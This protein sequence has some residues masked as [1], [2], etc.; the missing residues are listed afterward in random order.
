MPLQIRCWRALLLLT[1]ACSTTVVSA[2]QI[3]LLGIASIPGTASDL[4]GM[5]GTFSG[6]TPHNQM[7][8]FSALEYDARRNRYLV[9]PDRGPADGAFEYHC[10]FHE[11][12]ITLSPDKRQSVSAKL[13]ASHMLIDEKGHPFVGLAAAIND[14]HPELSRRFDP[15]GIRVGSDGT[16]YVC[17]EYGPHLFAFDTAGKLRKRVPVPD[18][19]VVAKPGVSQENEHSANKSGRQTNRGLEG[20]AIS[21]DGRRLYAML[22]GPLLQDHPEDRAGQRLGLNT[23]LYELNL[24]SGKTRELVYVLDKASYGISEIVMLDDQRILVLERDNKPGLEAKS[25]RIYEADFSKA[26]D[27]SQVGSLPATT[28]PTG[29]QPIR[30]RLFLDLLDK[31]FGLHNKELPAKIEGLA[32]GPDLSDGRRLLIVCSD[33]D[34]NRDQ[35]SQLYVFAV[36]SKF[37]EGR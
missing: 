12:E 22:Q 37:S 14:Q 35:P 27:V 17:D 29:V 36:S 31:R 16:V 21:A 8:G 15:E 26:T 11:F 33:N 23:R 7:G 4:S 13:L 30:K 1:V 3:E 10:R 32:F 24:D 19:F 5:K 28:L 25:K 18:H 6:G 9:L 34:F 2:E 20:L